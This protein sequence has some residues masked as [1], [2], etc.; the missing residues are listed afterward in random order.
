M[1]ITNQQLQ[2]QF[3]GFKALFN[4]TFTAASAETTWQRAGMQ[5]QS[6]TRAEEYGWLG[7]IPQVREWFGDRVVQAIGQHDY[8]IK[9]RDF[10]LTVAVDRNDIEDDRTG[11]YAP[12]IENM[13]QV[14]ATHPDRLVWSLLAAGFTELAYDGA[15]FFSASHPVLDADG[16]ETTASNL[17]SGAETPW[18]LVD[19]R[20][21][22]PLVFQQ[23]KPWEFLRMD[24]PTDEVVFNRKEYR[25]GVDARHNVGFAF[26]QVAH[27][28]KVA[29]TAD[30]YATAR[31]A[32]RTMT[33]DYGH[34]LSLRPTL[35]VAPPSLEQDARELLMAERNDSGATNVWRNTAELL[36][37]DWLGVI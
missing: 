33:A 35:L 24:A 27:G 32:M 5:V 30:N 18:F 7:Q 11:I 34:P 6:S 9:N 22:K 29:L 26:W 15:A 16:V 21:L 4:N 36:I 3:L 37:T 2:T 31:A 13:G 28:A 14:A 17:S 23:R 20:Y 12:L 1:P 19:T 25:Y 10:E 8:T